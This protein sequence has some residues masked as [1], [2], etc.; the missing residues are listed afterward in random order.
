VT[1]E[2]DWKGLSNDG[3]QMTERTKHIWTIID[4]PNDRFAKIVKADVTLMSELK[5]TLQKK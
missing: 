5:I 1:V 2:F 3:K 4:N